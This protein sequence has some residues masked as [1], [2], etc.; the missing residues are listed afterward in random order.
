MRRVRVCRN[1]LWYISV[2]ADSDVCRYDAIWRVRW[3]DA[4]RAIM[5][6]IEHQR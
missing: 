2:L 3:L 5:E 6:K 4:M 1:T